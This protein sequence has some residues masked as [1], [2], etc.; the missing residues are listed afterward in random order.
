MGRARTVY[1][2][3]TCA[4]KLLVLMCVS[5]VYI[6]CHNNVQAASM[7]EE[8]ARLIHVPPKMQG[9]LKKK[10]HIVVNWKTRYSSNRMNSIA[11]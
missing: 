9:W 2:K 5:I 8:K 4:A 11:I 3:V 6:L 7:A 1:Y 10:G